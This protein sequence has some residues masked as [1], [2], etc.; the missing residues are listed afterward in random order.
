MFPLNILTITTPIRYADGRALNSANSEKVH[1]VLD[2]TCL[3]SRFA[4]DLP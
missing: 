2:S 3:S 4:G 1:G